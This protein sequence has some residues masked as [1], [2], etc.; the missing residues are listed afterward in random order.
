MERRKENN[1]FTL[2]FGREPNEIIPR[3]S[4]MEDLVSAFT[5]ERPSQHIAMV[6]GIRGSGKTVF[7]TS[8]CREIAQEKDWVVAELSPEQDLLQGL[9]SRLGN[10]HKLSGIFQ[11]TQINLSYFGIGLKVEGSAPISDPGIALERI[12]ESLKKHGRRLLI[13]IDEVVNNQFVRIFAS[14]F[15]ILLRKDL[16]IFLLMTG[17]YENIRALQDE[18]TLT[19]L[20][21]APRIALQ[22]LN[23]G[24]MTDSYQRIFNLPREEAL[25]MARET[26]GY[27]FAFQVLGYFT[28]LYDSDPDRVRSL[29]RQYLE[30]FVYEKVWAEMSPQDRKVASAIAR[31]PDGNIREIRQ[32]LGMETNQFNPYRM[33]L[34]RKGVVNGDEYGILK[35]TLPLFEQ[36]ILENS[37]VQEDD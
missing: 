1:P 13:A 22:P 31:V 23:I 12:L 4:A 34:I 15:Q 11:R 27:S 35:F 29:Y 28:W 2:D 14:E 37:M 6:S 3:I 26:K 24:I 7:M 9:I 33:R 36:F 5:A 21:R 18:K 16:P 10:D 30:E 25:R 32:L 8:V 17:L 19:F 20:Y